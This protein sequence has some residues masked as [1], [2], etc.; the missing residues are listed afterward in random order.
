MRCHRPTCNCKPPQPRRRTTTT[1]RNDKPP[2]GFEPVS[3]TARRA[4]HVR[5]E[6]ERE[7]D[8]SRRAHTALG[9]GSGGEGMGVRHLAPQEAKFWLFFGPPAQPRKNAPPTATHARVA[10]SVV[11]NGE[12]LMP[13]TWLPTRMPMLQRSAQT[14]PMMQ[15]QSCADHYGLAGLKARASIAIPGLA[16]P[17]LRKNTSPASEKDR[18][19]E[20]ERER[21]RARERERWRSRLRCG[22]R[23]AMQNDELR[24]RWPLAIF[25]RKSQRAE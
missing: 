6:R 19:C 16:A 7:R 11:M 17:H 8:R 21:A 20:R 25:P 2:V 18:A 4:R 24:G 15:L 5:E 13:R 1:P 23:T 3:R 10:R 12:T 22:G 14:L 9:R